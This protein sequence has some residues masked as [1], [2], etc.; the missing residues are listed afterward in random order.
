VRGSGPGEQLAGGADRVDG[1]ALA[2][3]PLARVLAGID[4]LDMLA[5]RGQV[6]GQPQA[7]MPG[8]L[9]GPRHRE[10]ARLHAGPGQYGRVPVRVGGELAEGY[11]LPGP[12]ADRR[13]VRVAVGI[14][15]NDQASV[16]SA[17]HPSSFISDAGSAAPA[18]KGTPAVV[19]AMVCTM[20]SW[21]VS[22]RSR[23]FMVMCE[24]NRC[25]IWGEMRTPAGARQLAGAEPWPEGFCR[26]YA[27]AAASCTV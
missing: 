6:P 18:W 22:G 3:A 17:A 4:L 9:D 2:V 7:V 27:V 14:D 19:V 10:P 26:C 23:Q 24:N 5:G 21:L 25:S 8:T 11:G 16:L 13:S 15:T 12:V 20:T 1:I